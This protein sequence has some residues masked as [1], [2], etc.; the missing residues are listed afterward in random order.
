MTTGMCS[1]LSLV[2]NGYSLLPAIGVLQKRTNPNAC[3]T[4]MWSIRLDLTRSAKKVLPMSCHVAT[5]KL[6][7][8]V[9]SLV[10][11]CFLLLA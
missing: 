11:C 2:R 8:A 6:F 10:S 5:A 1:L 3:G 7:C 4:T 9:S